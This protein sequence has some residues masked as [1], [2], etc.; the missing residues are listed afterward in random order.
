MSTLLGS[1]AGRMMAWFLALLTFGTVVGL[2]ALWP[3]GS[4][5]EKFTSSVDQQNER[6]EVTGSRPSRVKGRG[7]ARPASASR[8]SC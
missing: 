7:P 2:I 8:S 1:Q 5:N 3:D 6:A 4:R